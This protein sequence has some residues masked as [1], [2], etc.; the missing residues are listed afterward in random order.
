MAF[1]LCNINALIP[2]ETI[3]VEDLKN[4]RR[5]IC[6][7]FLAETVSWKSMRIKKTAHKVRYPVDSLRQ[8]VQ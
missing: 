4:S 6:A 2:E 7:E 3:R 5:F 8:R 1:K